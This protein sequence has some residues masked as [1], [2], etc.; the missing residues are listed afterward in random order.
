MYL[1]QSSKTSHL[2]ANVTAFGAQL[3]NLRLSDVGSLFSLV[4]LV[5]QF[6]ELSEMG[7]G[8]LFLEGSVSKEQYQRSGYD[9]DMLFLHHI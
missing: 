7:V 3:V 8:L 2:G 9:T 1:M 4:Q 5:L 6:A